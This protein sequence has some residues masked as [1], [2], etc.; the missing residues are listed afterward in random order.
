MLVA[1]DDL[2]P[3]GLCQGRR[4]AAEKTTR[5][6]SE[7]GMELETLAE[8]NPLLRHRGLCLW[9]DG[10]RVPPELE[11][12]GQRKRERELE[13]DGGAEAPLDNDALTIEFYWQAPGGWRRPPTTMTIP[14]PGSI[15]ERGDLPH[16]SECGFHCS[17]SKHW[18]RNPVATHRRTAIQRV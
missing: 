3:I 2:G 10:A 4:D 15:G 17:Q 9:G 11:W 14:Y 6:Q 18:S 8:S 12:R 13:Q 16:L 5:N 7:E 1:S